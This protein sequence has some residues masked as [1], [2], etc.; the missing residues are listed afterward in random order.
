MAIVDRHDNEEWAIRLGVT[1]YP[2]VVQVDGYGRPLTETPIMGMS[3][4]AERLIT[5]LRNMSKLRVQSWRRP[6]INPT[7]KK[8]LNSRQIAA[9]QVADPIERARHWE[10]FVK[11]IQLSVHEITEIVPLIPDSYARL[12]LFRKLMEEQPKS[13]A[14]VALDHAWKETNTHV[15]MAMISSLSKLQSTQTDKLVLKYLDGV[16]SNK[17]NWEEKNLI[18]IKALVFVKENP[19]SV[20]TKVLG[21]IIDRKNPHNGA[22]LKAVEILHDL[23]TQHE[24]QQAARVLKKAEEEYRS[25]KWRTISSIFSEK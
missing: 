15:E 4:T 14:Q 19:S 7:I 1:S 3:R 22:W 2:K 20:F 5:Q 12:I 6:P 25:R 24:D 10:S 16:L 17:K 13:A 23:S 21:E 9:L 11:K 8:H 18:L